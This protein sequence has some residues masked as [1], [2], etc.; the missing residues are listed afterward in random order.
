LK[1]ERSFALDEDERELTA[2]RISDEVRS[3]VQKQL[4]WPYLTIGAVAIAAFT[5]ASWDFVEDTKEQ[6]RMDA[7]TAINTAVAEATLE[8]DQLEISIAR[9]AGIL[10]LEQERAE[11]LRVEVANKLSQLGAEASSISVLNEAVAELGHARREIRIDFEEVRARTD[12]LAVMGEELKSI[13]EQLVVLDAVN[14]TVYNDVID[15]I[16]QAQSELL[17]AESRTTVFLQ[18]AGG[19]R[20]RAQELS[21]LLSKDGFLMPGEE[22][23]SG[24]AGQRHVR[25]FHSDDEEHAN[26]LKDSV[27][28]SLRGLGVTNPEVEVQDLTTWRGE[29]PER[30]TL[31]LWIEI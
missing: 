6:V 13:A 16:E 8:I 4:F 31:E 9:A 30:G 11:L 15:K 27:E 5:Y 24:A 7:Q 10:H 23:H 19:T 18:F 22:R 14:G 21:S 28:R 3:S 25:F 2:R 20:A 17:T 1:I 12:S 26:R 29:K